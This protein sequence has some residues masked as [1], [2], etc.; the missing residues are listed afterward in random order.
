[1]RGSKSRT[2]VSYLALALSLSLY[3]AGPAAASSSG[4]ATADAVRAELARRHAP[5]LAEKAVT[6]D[7]GR[8]IGGRLTELI[9]AARAKGAKAPKD[10]VR[11]VLEALNYSAAN[12]AG[13]PQAAFDRPVGT[14]LEKYGRTIAP[15]DIEARAEGSACPVGGIGAGGYE[16]LMN[17]NFSTWFLKPGW[18]VEDTVWADQFHVYMK[19]AGRTVARTLST[20][21]P[22]DGAGLSRWAWN[23]PV[24]KGDYFALYPKSGFSYEENPDLP[25]D[26]AVVQFSP[27]IAGNYKETS[28]PVAVYRWIAV[29]PAKQPVDVSILL[30]WE[31]M[32]GW[33]AVR[34]RPASGSAP[35]ASF[36]WDRK[37]AGNVNEFVE[38]GRAKGIL[39]RRQGQDV[40]TGNAMSG[41]MAIAVLDSPARTRVH[42]QAAFDPK[43]DGA[44]IW[45]RFAADGTLDGT[46]ASTAAAAGQA[47]GAG[48]AVSFTLK[49]GERLEIPFAVAWDLPYYEFEAG[50]KQ[51]RK[52]TAFYGADGTNAFRIA[53]EGLTRA[54]EWERAVDAWQKPILADAKLPDWFKQALL[55]ELYVLAETSIWDAVT[56]LHTYLES[57]DY[58]M[59]GTTDVDSYCWHVLKLW[60]ELEKRNMEFIARTIPLE[61]STFRAYQY[62]VTFPGEVP[63]DKLDYYW[64]TI[65]VPGMVPHDLGSPRKRPWTVLNGFDW[66]NGNVWKDLNPKFPL[67]AY[68]DFLADG[69]I[70]MGFLMKM[71]EASVAALDTLERRFGDKVSHVPLNEGIP[72]Q[73][74][75]T[76]RMEGQSAYVGLLWLAGLKATVRMGETLEFRGLART[77]GIDI[78]GAV[79]KYRQ[80][81]EAGRASLRRL[82]DGGGRVLPHRRPDGRR[83]G[84]PALR[85]L[86]LGHARARVRRRRRH[87]PARRRRPDAPDDLRQER[88]RLRGRRHGRRQRPQGRRRP[89][90]RPAGRRGLGRHGLRLRRQLRPQR[91]RRGR[92]A[93]GLRPLPRRLEPARP[94][95]FLQDARSV[96]RSGRGPVERSVGEVRRE[97]VPGH[98][99][100][101]SGGGLGALRSAV[102]KS[103][104]N[105][106]LDFRSCVRKTVRSRGGLR[107]GRSPSLRLWA[108]SSSVPAG[109]APVPSPG[110]GRAGAWPNPTSS[111]SPST[112]R[113]PT[114][115]RATAAPS[116]KPPTSTPW[117]PGARSSSRRPPPRR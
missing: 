34:A 45:T 12:L 54:G 4:D 32:V 39:F 98:E 104:L 25:V 2:A 102:E 106:Y 66:Q 3:F 55:N 23:Y 76:W 101:A 13:F 100:H 31:N 97:D 26:L 85:G 81:F 56:D 1:M 57:A 65:K 72:D 11:A 87:R 91:A 109:A 53:A 103:V 15:G 116:S 83:H 80:W 18:M 108:G 51:K 33:E 67:R 7:T 96:S 89:A 47:T 19:S 43:G 88:P 10:V 78:P 46:K 68:R 27:V 8:E 62:A 112:P 82:W 95:L 6:D 73:T 111:W 84:R 9:A 115:S 49:P 61:D 58:L 92:P 69:G 29:N 114:I 110:S 30:T 42:F 20:T 40:R 52:Y 24:G 117:P 63:A 77:S 22:P 5:L 79:A 64:N 107:P 41:S 94:G 90:P 71:F 36:V 14:V 50:A 16:R 75:D 35:Q 17:G 28:Y 48:L 105:G 60:P 59:Y 38:A 74:Y 21:A 44:D 93:H 70:D 113:G 37:S 86:V 99:V